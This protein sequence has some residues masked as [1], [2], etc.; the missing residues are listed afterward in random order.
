MNLFKKL[1]L[2]GKVL[3][4]TELVLLVLA[5]VSVFQVHN[6][7]E[8]QKATK[9]AG[10]KNAALNMG[11]LIGKKFRLKYN[12]VQ[13]IAENRTFFGS[14]KKD[15]A[16]VLNRFVE[17]NDGYSLIV[18]ADKEGNFVAANNTNPDGDEIKSEILEGANFK[19][20]AW[21][22][23]ALAEEYTDDEDK[24]LI[25]SYVG[26][27]G[28]DDLVAKVNGE[29]SFGNHFSTAVT[30]L[31]GEVVGVMTTRLDFKWVENS[32]VDLFNTMRDEGFP[33]TRIIL[34][35]A[36]GNSVVDFQPSLKEGKTGFDRLKFNQSVKPLFGK[37]LKK[38]A[39][40]SAGIY[41]HDGY[42]GGYS[43][44][45]NDVVA[46]FGWGIII[47]VD[48]DELLGNLSSSINI[49]YVMVTGI[50]LLAMIFVWFFVDRIS[51]SLVK[52]VVLLKERVE[53]SH[54]T[55]EKLS[56]VSDELA[57]GASEQA[58]AVQETVASMTEMTSM[59]NQTSKH[60]VE[61][62]DLAKEVNV[63]TQEGSEI[64]EEMVKSMHSIQ[65]ANEQLHEMKKIISEITD[66]TKVINDIVFKTQLLSFNASIE[67]ARAGQ[68]GRG[69]AVV[70]EEVGN[71]AQMSGNAANEIAALLQKSEDQVGQIV[72][73][74]ASR[75][76]QGQEVSGKAL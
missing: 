22:D 52:M 6:L 12:Q 39:E 45:V 35:D 14:D 54:E 43:S 49:F 1:S 55:S 46:S 15:M 17:R 60:V 51:Q 4:L 24:L 71:L 26:S 74:T 59:I 68:H 38:I 48:T 7:S 69:F 5:A 30:N 11:A 31:N 40:G 67:A 18:F 76:E 3:I 64:M 41:N 65:E 19:G 37:E 21:F 8:T 53:N 72:E 10:F 32:F 25:G 61:S 57:S 42:V 56:K 27:I 66:K 33:S 73:N 20:Q 28:F 36:V 9:A 16:Y 47:T 44:M 62:E 29:N 23:R 13:T 70:A 34:T 58:A 75:V 63:R 2:R 50:L